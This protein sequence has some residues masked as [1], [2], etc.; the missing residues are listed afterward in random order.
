MLLEMLEQVIEV[1]TWNN[2]GIWRKYG[3]YWYAVA[4]GKCVMYKSCRKSKSDYRIKENGTQQTQD[5]V[6]A[7]AGVSDILH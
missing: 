7:C 3:G 6:P 5:D 4:I 2:M 1:W